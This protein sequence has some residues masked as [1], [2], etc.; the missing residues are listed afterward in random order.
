MNQPERKGKHRAGAIDSG[1]GGNLRRFRLLAGLSQQ[2]VAA[3]LG[4]TFQQVQKYENGSNRVT[5]A[6]LPKL[7]KLYGV[8]YDRFFAGIEAG[9]IAADESLAGCDEYTLRLCRRLA[10]IGDVTLRRKIGRIIDTLA[11]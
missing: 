3:A 8:S 11:S 4:V 5:A 1:I 10:A 6:M 7:K 2:D 9:E